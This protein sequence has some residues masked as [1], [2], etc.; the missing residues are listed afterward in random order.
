M[1][2]KNNPIENQLQ[3]EEP[4]LDFSKKRRERISIQTFKTKVMMKILSWDYYNLN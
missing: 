2:D 4:L 1:F 3:Q